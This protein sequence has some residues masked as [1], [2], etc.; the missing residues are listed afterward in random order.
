[1]VNGVPVTAAAGMLLGQVNSH[2]Q[3]PCT[4]YRD[5]RQGRFL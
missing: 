5:D 4:R 3:L 1:M 2:A